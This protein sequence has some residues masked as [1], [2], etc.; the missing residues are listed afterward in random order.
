[1]KKIYYSIMLAALYLE[2]VFSIRYLKGLWMIPDRMAL[3]EK[4]PWLLDKGQWVVLL[5]PVLSIIILLVIG[6]VIYIR[7][8][9]LSLRA[10][11]TLCGIVTVILVVCI[12]MN[13]KIHKAGEPYR[14]AL[15]VANQVVAIGGEPNG[16][17]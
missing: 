15:E 9:Q 5:L 14:G 12:G 6:S 10:Y 4:L 7:S 17:W 8:I 2:I 1:M 11:Q 13:L 16:F 3:D